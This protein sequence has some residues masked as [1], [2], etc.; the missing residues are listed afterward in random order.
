[1]DARTLIRR[2]E[3]KVLVKEAV[4]EAAKEIIADIITDTKIRLMDR[5]IDLFVA[6]VVIA[7]LALIAWAQ[8]WFK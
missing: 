8:G 1:M 4:K 2:Q 7:C 5:I 6:S 3:N